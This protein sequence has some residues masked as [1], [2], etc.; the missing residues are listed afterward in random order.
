MAV[1]F[2]SMRDPDLSTLGIDVAMRNTL[3]RKP[4]GPLQAEDRALCRQLLIEWRDDARA[5]RSIFLMREAYGVV[6]ASTFTR[7]RIHNL[8]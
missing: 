4:V 2:A 3:G 6:P 5:A 1:L 8:P 7:I